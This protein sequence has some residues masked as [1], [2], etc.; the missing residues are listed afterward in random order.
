MYLSLPKMSSGS[1]APAGPHIISYTKVPPLFQWCAFFMHIP[2]PS[3]QVSPF[4]MT[5]QTT[6]W[7]NAPW[8]V[9]RAA[10]SC[11][12]R[13]IS[14]LAPS[15][16]IHGATVLFSCHFVWHCNS[17]C[18]CM[19]LPLADGFL[20]K[21]DAPCHLRQCWDWSSGQTSFSLCIGMMLC[22]HQAA[23]LFQLMCYGRDITFLER[24]W[25]VTGSLSGPQMPI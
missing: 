4:S 21:C 24:S 5:S 6:G 9:G 16:H 19:A 23:V 25:P 7:H 3:A 13:D 15:P 10:P 18:V 11:S 20:G 2:R 8:L 22:H 14:Q 17:Y 12:P 1:P